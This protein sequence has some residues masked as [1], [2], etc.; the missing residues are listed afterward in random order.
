MFG[1]L[2]IR[3]NDAFIF[4]E[5]EPPIIN[6]RYGWSGI[7]CHLDCVLL[8]LLLQ[9]NQSWTFSCC[10]YI[11]TFKFLFFH[12][13]SFHKK[14]FLICLKTFYTNLYRFFK[15]V[16]YWNFFWGSLGQS[17]LFFIIFLNNFF[18]SPVEQL[19]NSSDNLEI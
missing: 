3:F 2:F 5:P 1:S 16:F 13:R 14:L 4:P 6:I 15:I 10:Y 18:F 11:I 12:I 17:T 8:C 9:Y 7:S 19:L